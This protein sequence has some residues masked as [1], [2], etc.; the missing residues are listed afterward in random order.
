MKKLFENVSS[1]RKMFGIIGVCLIIP[2]LV[3][4]DYNKMV[5]SMA[6]MSSTILFF[7][8]P[9]A[10]LPVENRWIR[11]G[12]AGIEFSAILLICSLLY[13]YS[14]K[15]AKIYM[16]AIVTYMFIGMLFYAYFIPWFTKK[17]DLD[18]NVRTNKWLY[19]DGNGTLGYFLLWVFFLF[20]EMYIY[21]KDNYIYFNNVDYGCASVKL[22]VATN[23]EDEDKCITETSQGN[24]SILS[25]EY[26]QIVK[27]NHNT[28][29]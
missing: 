29:I 11:L 4:C 2:A 10:N 9:Y 24:F 23:Y 12:W 22:C 20:V 18:E 6:I 14:F 1:R 25:D 3:F 28:K 17:F 5:L 16:V 7:R 27:I 15:G 26:T 21:R 19:S 13:I 8:L